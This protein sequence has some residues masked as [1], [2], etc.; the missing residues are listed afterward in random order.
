MYMLFDSESEASSKEAEL[1]SALGYP[2]PSTARYA[3]PFKHATQGQWAL[4]ICDVWNPTKG[5]MA[6]AYSY[7]T[8]A[9]KDALVG[10]ATLRDDGWFDHPQDDAPE[11][12]E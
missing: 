9:E 10:M 6:S 8:D 2:S 3:E 5:Q 11:G 1:S 12:L 7:I 4:L